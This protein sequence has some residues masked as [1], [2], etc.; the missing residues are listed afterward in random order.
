MQ[1]AF[2]PIAIIETYETLPE[3]VARI[4]ESP[5]GLQAGIF[6]QRLAEILHCW[7]EIECG[8]IIV[9]DIPTWRVDQMPYGGMKRS[10]VGREG[11]RYSI[12]E[13]TEPKLLAIRPE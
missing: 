12:E 11:V 3:V 9:N 1:E 6:T 10:G 7:R 2:A 4:N 5:F 8:G 13:M